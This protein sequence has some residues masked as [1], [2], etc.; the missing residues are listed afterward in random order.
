MTDT[1]W[2]WSAVAA[3]ERLKS[4]E[5]SPRELLASIRQRVEAVDPLVNALPTLCFDRA[6]RFA[7]QLEE[8]A[9]ADRGR[10]AGLPWPIKDSAAVSGVRTTWGSLAYADHVPET[11]DYVVEAIEAEGG[12][13]FAKSNTPEFE[14]GANTFNEVFGRTLNPWNLSRSAGGSSG[15]AAVAVATGMAFLAQGSDFACS[16]RYPAAFC[17]VV[18]L[19]PTPGVVPQGPSALPGQVLSV[20]GPL[21][22]NVDDVALALDGMARF[23]PRDPLSRPCSPASFLAAAQAPRAPAR[24]AFSMTIGM[25]AVDRAVQGTVGQ[26]LDTLV[27]SGLRADE[28]CPDL[29]AS[30]PAFRTLRAFQF[31]A[32]RRGV[33]EQH[34]DKLKPEVIWNIEQ[35]LKLTALELAGAEAD[36]AR[37]RLAML[38]F[39]DR[40]GVLITPTAPVEPFPVEQRYVEHI[41]GQRLATYLDWL[42]LGYAITVCGCPAISI[43]C[44]RTSTGLPVGLQLVGK[45]HGEAELLRTAAWCEGVLGQSLTRPIDPREHA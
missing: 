42:V 41:D 38:E 39:L 30:D 7:G 33:L 29:A 18:G 8:A 36:R 6:E 43:P 35:G 25:A 44:G 21:A 45:P 20:M 3:V 23:D 12:V 10:L 13:I 16:L 17:N 22:R 34:R 28:A 5:I 15:G 19:R 40:H 37:V 26:A 27:A 2:T 31:A 32:L 4:G 24:A 14:A 11:S 1:P 9:V